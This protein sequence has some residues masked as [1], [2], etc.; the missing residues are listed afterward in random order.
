M[1]KDGVNIRGK[2]LKLVDYLADVAALESLALCGR[3]VYFVSA[4]GLRTVGGLYS[5]NL[6]GGLVDV[7]LNNKTNSCSEIK[8]ASFKNILAFTDS[9]AYQVRVYDPVDKVVTVPAGVVREE[10][11][12]GWQ[13]VALL[14][15]RTESAL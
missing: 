14:F 3:L 8:C 6:P 9:K 12:M 4:K 15:N 11:K 1:E 7:L 10:M 2:S 5:F 13:K